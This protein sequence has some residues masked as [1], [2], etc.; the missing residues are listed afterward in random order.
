MFYPIVPL[1]LCMTDHLPG[2]LTA[3][4]TA[5][6]LGLRPWEMPLEV[7]GVV[8]D[9]RGRVL[10]V[11]G[12][13]GGCVLPGGP[14][15]DAKDPEALVVPEDALTQF[16]REGSGWELKVGQILA[17]DVD[18]SCRRLVYP[19]QVRSS[20]L[21]SMPGPGGRMA[22]FVDKGKALKG[23]SA[24]EGRRLLGALHAL[25]LG[26]VVHMT[27]GLPTASAEASPARLYQAYQK[28]QY[29]KDAYP[30]EL[31]IARRM[32]ALGLD[33][34]L[35]A[36]QN[37]SYLLR[38]VEHAVRD[39]GI[40]QFL[41][42]GTGLPAEPDPDN[43]AQALNPHQVAQALDPDVR[44]VCVDNDRQVTRH[45]EARLAGRPDGT[46]SWVE[47]DL[48]AP[49]TI[50]REASRTLDLS[51][52][53][54]LL[55]SAVLHFVRD[56]HHPRGIMRA[57]LSRLAPGSCIIVSHMTDAHQPDVMRRAESVL[58]EM[59]TPS[60]IRSLAAIEGLLSGLEVTEPGLVPVSQW[61]Q[62]DE[63]I[64]ALPAE[65]VPCYAAFAVL[66]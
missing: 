10:V 33:P 22:Q 46:T 14:V 56:A 47:A 13:D 23:L 51:R 16:L 9:L 59:G 62:P 49:E 30:R 44:F 1:E 52:P 60:Q 38:A 15:P 37:R 53:V 45:A 11:D 63:S 57:L 40:G 34:K 24:A 36:E 26:Q 54:G 41:D 28:G 27:S 6:R 65:Q 21:S 25:Q 7:F 66:R 5:P 61:R 8:T 2:R 12:E 42:I 18:E 43:P 17:V 3:S 64:R 29:A 50:L 58:M 55:L 20:S 31:Y 39:W 35:I 4:P 48:R 32:A 19:S